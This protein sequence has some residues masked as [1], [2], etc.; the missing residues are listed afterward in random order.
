MTVRVALFRAVNIGGHNKLPMAELVRLLED[1]GC[2]NVRTYV[3]SG[4][5]VFR[6]DG[7]AATLAGRIGAAVE[8]R[9]GFR[10]GVLVWDAGELERAV[11]G[12][13]FPEADADPRSLH[14]FFLSERPRDPDLDALERAKAASERFMLGGRVLYFHAPDGVGRSKIPARVEAALGVEATGRNW[15]TVRKLLEITRDAG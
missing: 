11:A 7:D 3:Q 1:L 9:H 12:N 10:P 15:R 14:L 2:R 5:A 13:P 4:N 6:R 8:Q